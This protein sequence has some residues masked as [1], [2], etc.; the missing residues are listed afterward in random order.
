MSTPSSIA[1]FLN[2]LGPVAVAKLDAYPIKTNVERSVTGDMVNSAFQDFANLVADLL[3]QKQGVL[4]FDNTPA[5]GSSNPV[6]SAGIAEAIT[7][8][9][10]AALVGYMTQP[11]V[12]A[13]IT[14]ALA[15]YSTTAQTAQQIASAIATALADYSTTAQM[16]TAITDAINTALAAYDTHAEVVQEISDAIAAALTDYVTGEQ[17]T[18]AIAAALTDYVTTAA[19]NTALAGKQDKL[20]AMGSATKPVYVYADGT[21]APCDDYAGGTKV[22]LNGEDKGGK[23]ISIYAPTGKGNA[24]QYYGS[25]TPDAPGWV[26]PDNA[27][28]EGSG[29]LVKSGGIFTA[30]ANAVTGAVNT[31]KTWAEGIF[32]KIDG[33]YQTLTA[34]AAENLV[35]RGTTPAVISF[36]PAGGTQDIGTGAASIAKIKGRTDAVNQIVS[37]PTKILA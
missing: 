13:A 15:P 27:P 9:I 18:T 23:S 10:A 17:M 14:A 7:N 24:E 5:A 20:T 28:T 33:Y 35:G 26:T 8:Q 19:M 36:R 29:K 22:V 37:T 2:R 16:Q 32:A 1:D 6:T 4:T 21:L 11:Q 34:G 25:K 31:V 30:I 12:A 3:S